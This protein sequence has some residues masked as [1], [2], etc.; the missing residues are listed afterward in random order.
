MDDI[1]YLT[2]PLL[3]LALLAGAKFAGRG[4]YNPE[5]MSLKNTKY[6]QGF[7][8]ICV[9]LHHMGQKTCA[10][11]HDPK[12][13]VHGLD[14]FVGI[15]YLFVAI[16]FFYS[17]YGLF[18]SFKNKPDYLHGFVKHRIIPI[19]IAF[20]MAQLIFL[21]ARY[22]LGEKISTRQLL[23]Y[24]TGAQLCNINTW[25][26]IAIVAFY[27]AFYFS[28]KY[29]KNENLAIFATFLAVFAW[30]FIGTC[31]NH[32]DWWMRGEWWYNSVHTFWM[33]LVFAKFKKPI[34]EGIKKHYFI[35]LILAIVLF[36]ASWKLC[37]FVQNGAFGFSYYCETSWGPKGPYATPLLVKLYKKWGVLAAQ[38]LYSTLFLVVVLLISMKVQVGNKVLAFMG[39]ITVTTNVYKVA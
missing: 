8:A 29:I 22:L 38:I 1:I 21:P 16:F 27:F 4:S 19:I 31:I 3:L 9:M 18:V 36:Y 20:Y 15:G 12:Y 7:F 37:V 11:W 25:F 17:G 23:Y 10:S 30:T 28:F 6:I 39:N 2:Y 33:G 5:F 14:M 26:P 35:Y 24:L 13:I 34:T 32:N